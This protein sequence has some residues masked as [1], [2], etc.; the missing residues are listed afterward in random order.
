MNNKKKLSLNEL[1]IKSF[2]TDLDSQSSQEIY[3]GSS[4][5]PQCPAS[6]YPH[7]PSGVGCPPTEAGCGGTGGGGSN[8]QNTCY[9][10]CDYV[11]DPCA[12]V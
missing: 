10:F 11:S 1:K 3:G 2:V 7:C 12:C 8:G 4:C 6:Y 9:T 5:P